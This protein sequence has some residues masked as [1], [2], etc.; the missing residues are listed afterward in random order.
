MLDTIAPTDDTLAAVQKWQPDAGCLAAGDQYVSYA[1]RCYAA[2]GLSD[3]QSKQRVCVL[4]GV[5][6]H[7]YTPAFERWNAAWAVARH[8]AWCGQSARRIARLLGHLSVS[9]PG[10]P[11]EPDEI[12]GIAR[13]AISEASV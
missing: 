5:C 13:A 1:N 3:A 4:S 7:A 8:A 10:S 6:V 9:L 11:D 12:A 2:A